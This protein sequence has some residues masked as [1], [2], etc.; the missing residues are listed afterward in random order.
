MRTFTRVANM[1]PGLRDTGD[2]IDAE[3]I[4]ELQQAAEDLQTGA[5]PITLA[6]IE[7]ALGERDQQAGVVR[8]ADYV[9]AGVDPTGVADSYAGLALAI[10]AMNSGDALDLGNGNVYRISDDLVFTG[11]FRVIGNSTILYSRTNPAITI[12]PAWG[13]A[14]DI[15]AFAT[16]EYPAGIGSYCAKLSVADASGFAVGDEALIYSDDALV[17]DAGAKRGELKTVVGVATGA[18]F[19]GGILNDTYT[20]SPKVR[21][22]PSLSCEIDGPTFTADGDPTSSETGRARGAIQAVGLGPA[23]SIRCR[24]VD[25]WSRGLFLIGCYGVTVD[26]TAH[27]CRDDTDHAAYGYGVS[28]GPGCRA[29]MI[30]AQ[31]RLCRHTVTTNTYTALADGWYGAPRECVVHDSLADSCTS[32][33]FDTHPGAYNITFSNCHAL[34]SNEGDASTSGQRY[35]FQNRSCD[36]TYIGCSSHGRCNFIYEAAGLIN[37]GQNSVTRIVG[38]WDEMTDADYAV[39]SQAQAI[40][41]PAGSYHADSLTSIVDFY[42]RNKR[43]IDEP[44]GQI[45]VDGAL[46]LNSPTL[47][48]LAGVTLRLR[49]VR[50]VWTRSGSMEPILLRAGTILYL[51]GYNAEGTHNPN[52]LIRGVSGPGTWT[53]YGKNVGSADTST[54]KTDDGSGTWNVVDT[55]VAVA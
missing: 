18:I 7:G 3:H 9:D 23:S 45:T 12:T 44:H 43:F 39:S 1:S 51:D 17:A 16:E 36:T 50:R 2:E 55:S 13:P 34:H 40:V 21:K 32:A 20:T 29:C 4:N 54:F 30:R 26:V 38:C 27:R 37:H 8:A 28:I 11:D 33:G 47:R 42:V 46:L 19:L 22:H 41:Q 48:I 25:T 24:F 52:S 6:G 14:H 5:L 31:G 53:V 35:A 49:N 15:T 10:A